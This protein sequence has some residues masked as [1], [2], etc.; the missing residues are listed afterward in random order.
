VD[1]DSLKGVRPVSWVDLLRVGPGAMV[2]VAVSALTPEKGIDLLVE[3]AS[4]LHR[5]YPAL[6][7]VI[8]GDGPE[9]PALEQRA[10]ALQVVPVV[11]FLGNLADP[12]PLIAGATVLVVP[13]RE[14]GFGTVILDA[15]GLG[16]PV[17]GAAVG[18]I[19][20]ALAAGGGDLF[21]PGSPEALAQAVEQLVTR[22][23][24]RQRLAR[25]GPAA[26]G[27]FALPAMVD[28]VAALY[29]SVKESI[30]AQ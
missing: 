29:R 15:L 26:A 16:I 19:P 14:E 11:H 13:S 3:A 22:P 9:R 17:I 28:R 7:W 23:A 21:E 6:H 2:L 4:V 10:G 1:L 24:D 18:G 25:E 20:Q 27:R 5:R 12:L 8:A 30:E